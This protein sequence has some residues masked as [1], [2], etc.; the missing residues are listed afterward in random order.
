LIHNWLKQP[1]ASGA[2]VIQPVPVL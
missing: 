1:N 2:Q